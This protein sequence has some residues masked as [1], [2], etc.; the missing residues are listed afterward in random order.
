MLVPVDY[1]AQFGKLLFLLK[2]VGLLFDIINIKFVQRSIRNKGNHS[3]SKNMYTHINI[4]FYLHVN[5]QSSTSLEL[6]FCYTNKASWCI[7]RISVSGEQD[8]KQSIPH[9]PFSILVLVHF[10]T[11]LL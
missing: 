3:C 10:P 4:F 7:Q 9:R 2:E 1:F 5:L 8:H 6:N 11:A